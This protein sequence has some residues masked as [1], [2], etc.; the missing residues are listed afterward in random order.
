MM[1]TSRA[2]RASS[3][4]PPAPGAPRK[5]RK[6][7]LTSGS[8]EDPGVLLSPITAPPAC[9]A[10]GIHSRPIPGQIAKIVLADTLTN[11]YH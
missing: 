6:P 4:D 8:E 10:R 5:P 3:P 2:R 11:C 9:G 7:D 1:G